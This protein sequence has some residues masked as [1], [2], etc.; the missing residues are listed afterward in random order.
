MLKNKTKIVGPI[1]ALIILMLISIIIFFSY[2]SPLNNSTIIIKVACI[3][4]SITE[5]SY[6]PEYLQQTLGSSYTV[7]N[8]GVSGATVL[9]DTDRPYMYQ[10]NCQKAKMFLPNI[11]IIMLGTNDA[12]E[13]IFVSIDNFVSQYIRL[14]NEFRT[15]ESNPQI[16]I[17]YPPPIFPNEMDISS[18]NLAEGIIPRIN[19]ISIESGLPTINVFDAL[20]NC[21]DY[22]LDGVHP[23]KDGAFQI[24]SLVYDSIK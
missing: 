6:Y 11:V 2:N 4:D 19:Q 3:G 14:I 24:A 9:I 22:F 23:N 12:K 17:A 16:W 13:N 20:S 8:F 21:S 10:D 18:Q 5:F 7:K 15:L 1:S